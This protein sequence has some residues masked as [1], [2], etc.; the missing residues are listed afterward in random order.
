MTKIYSCVN[1][2]EFESATDFMD[3]MRPSSYEWGAS[4]TDN[5]DW[6]F[7]GHGDADWPLLPSALRDKCIL[8]NHKLSLAEVEHWFRST[9]DNG[10]TSLISRKL[11][12]QHLAE[13]II[14]LRFNN[15][16]DDLGFPRFQSSALAIKPRLVKAISGE[17]P[18]VWQPSICHAIAQHHGVP[19]RLL[20]WSRDPLVSA[21]FA[22]RDAIKLK[23]SGQ[24]TSQFCVWALNS[25]AIPMF[26]GKSR[27]FEIDNFHSSFVH[28][29][30]GLFTW[31]SCDDD[32]NQTERWI[33]F[34]QAILDDLDH[35]NSSGG[36]AT[37]FSPSKWHD[38][39]HFDSN[40][41]LRKYLLPVEEAKKLLDILAR[42][43]RLLAHLMPT[44]DN[45]AITICEQWINE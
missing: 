15:L 9:S 41:V 44:L 7:R 22:A 10:S 17:E 4:L 36:S 45:V 33:P 14:L 42:E 23:Q 25:W 34:D 40:D 8:R 6:V 26:S 38:V 18:F 11:A 37:E 3:R 5:F 27:T 35:L 39:G 28:A 24:T 29:Q 1:V 2:Y 12:A 20:D 43:R 32:F 16:C 21:F 31:V 19:T 30:R 13:A